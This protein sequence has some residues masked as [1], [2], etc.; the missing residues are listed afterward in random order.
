MADTDEDT[1]TES[2]RVDERELSPQNRRLLKWLEDYMATPQTEEDRE[3]G[4]QFRK[5]LEEHRLD[6]RRGEPQ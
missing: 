4:R 6:L 5:F 3:W 1:R 2:P